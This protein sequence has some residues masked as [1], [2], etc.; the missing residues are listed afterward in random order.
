MP[1]DVEGTTYSF[2]GKSITCYPISYLSQ[3]LEKYLGEPRTPQTIRKWE[4][5]EIIPKPIFTTNGCR[6][7]TAEQVE[8]IC[9]NARD[10]GIKRGS[11][12]GMTEFSVRVWAELR[13]NYKK[14]KEYIAKDDKETVRYP[15][16]K[17]SK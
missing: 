10:S 3:Q 4:K 16:M 6:L 14:T 15:K 13:E 8:I 2:G 11:G 1:I 17:R 5:N 12:D 7:Y 9:R